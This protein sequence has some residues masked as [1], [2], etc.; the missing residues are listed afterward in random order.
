LIVRSSFRWSLRAAKVLT[1]ILFLKR[2]DFKNYIVP[3]YTSP[4]NSSIK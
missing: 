2:N 1:I 4:F 3:I